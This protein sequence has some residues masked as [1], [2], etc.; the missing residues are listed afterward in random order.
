MNK[1]EQTRRKNLTLIIAIF[2]IGI[3][4]YLG[5]TPLFN[6]IEGGVAGA[7]IGASFGAIFVI[8]LTMY[9][10]N[11][12]T[13][14][15]QESKKG[16][17]VFEEKVKIY[18]KIL[19]QTKSMVEDGAISK[20]EIAELPFLM[21]ELQ[22][23][24]GDETIIAYEGVFSTINEIFNEDEEE[25]VVTIDEN[26]KIKIYR[27]MLDFVRNCR[28]DL[29][30]SD[31]EINEK[32]FEATINTIQ[33]AEEITQGIKKG[34]AKGWMTIEEFLQECKKRGRPPELIETT[35]KLHDELMQHYRSEPLFAIDIPDFT[36][37]QSQYRFKAKT[38]KGVFC[39]ITLRTKDV[40]IGNIN[41]SPRWDYKQLK[42]GE[43]FFEHWREDPRKLKIDG[44]TGI[45]EQELKKI[46]VVLDESKK[47]LEEG[48]VLKD[49][50]RDKKR[51][52]EEAK[53]KFEALL[54]EETRDLDN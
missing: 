38:G 28:V 12:Q 46:L 17:R 10:L 54:D 52:D 8:V 18:Q 24:G 2:I 42:S 22:V 45:D 37:S 40:R 31:R 35:R 43:L 23:L 32:L 9:L 44:I 14:I 36:K 34:K 21:M 51:G 47:V 1:L 53:K 49:Y 30:V 50:R 26:A 33:N 19:T 3:A 27:K 7:V 15:E 6:L 48:K 5:F 25:D 29:G 13:E 4:V 11:K 39:E 20:S 16:E 41:K